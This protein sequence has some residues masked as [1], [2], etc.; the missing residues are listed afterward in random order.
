MTSIMG[1]SSRVR[2][3]S[4]TGR[5]AMR[6]TGA[7]CVEWNAQ[8]HVGHEGGQPLPSKS[9]EHAI[10]S[11]SGINPVASPTIRTTAKIKRTR[12]TARSG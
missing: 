4:A 5:S 6:V 3:V 7:G 12:H 11:A 10:S 2:A 1:G 8:V 9:S